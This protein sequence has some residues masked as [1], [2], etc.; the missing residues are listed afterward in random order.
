MNY[1]LA[2]RNTNGLFNK[3]LI[4]L[5]CRTGVE[6]QNT[7]IFPIFPATDKWRN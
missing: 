4:S 3:I 7:G 5:A 2:K 6:K 1:I